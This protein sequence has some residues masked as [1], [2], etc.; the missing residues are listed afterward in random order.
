MVDV[1][2]GIVGDSVRKIVSFSPNFFGGILILLIGLTIAAILKRIIV[3]IL[4]FSKL[5]VLLERAKLMKN[6]EFRLWQEVFAEI[7]KWTTVIIFLLPALEIWEL[8]RAT[9][10]LNQFLFYLPNVLVAVII[11][12]IGLLTSNLAS[13]IVRHSVESLRAPLANTLAIFAK[14]TI[15]FFTVLIIMNQL[16]VAQDLVRILFT[17]IVAMIALA[18]GLAFGLGGKDMASEILLELKK[19]LK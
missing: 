9:V 14:G 1:V 10:V 11:G 3:S 18:G 8:Q 16:G 15:I 4:S 7:A 19:K 12:F 6:Q 2:N 17:G 5:G 13:D